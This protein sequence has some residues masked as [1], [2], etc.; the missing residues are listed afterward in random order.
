MK[1]FID[2]YLSPFLARGI[3]ILETHLDDGFEVLSIKDVFGRDDGKGVKDEEWIPQVGKVGGVVITQDKNI[4]RKKLQKD[5]FQK[6]GI[7]M[8]FISPPK[9]GYTYWQMVEI[10]IKEWKDIKEKCSTKK[11][12]SFIHR[13]RSGFKRW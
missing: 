6:H 13:P 8:F 11:P 4:H 2:E 7:G 12:F 5:L 10:L 9:K 3:H 1:I